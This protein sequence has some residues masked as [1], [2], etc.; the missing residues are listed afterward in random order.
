LAASSIS[1][2][3][4]PNRLAGLFSSCVVRASRQP[5]KLDRGFVADRSVRSLLV[6]L[7]LSRPGKPTDN[8]F[9]ES[10]REL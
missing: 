4:S 10:F 6:T 8:A 2:Y 7:D 1:S 5:L 9:I 3:K